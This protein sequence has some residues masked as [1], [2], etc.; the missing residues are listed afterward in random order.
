MKGDALQ[1][2][3]ARKCQSPPLMALLPCLRHLCLLNPAYSPTT[4]LTQPHHIYTAKQQAGM[5]PR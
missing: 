1:K 5:Y 2:I 4:A 3:A